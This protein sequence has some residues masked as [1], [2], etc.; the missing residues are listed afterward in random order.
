MTSLAV[1]HSTGANHQPIAES[2]NDILE[3]GRENLAETL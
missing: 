1:G 2:L 3:P